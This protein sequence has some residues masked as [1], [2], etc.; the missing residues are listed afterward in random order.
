EEM[1]F[2]E[3]LHQ[4]GKVPLPP[5]IKREAEDGDAERYQTTY[6]RFDGSVA[7][8]TAGLHFT[9]N[10][11]NNLKQKEI[12][13]DFVT[14]HV[15]AGTF[16]PVKSETMEG[17]QMHAEYI[18]VN[19][20]LIEKLLIQSEKPIVAVGTTSMRT[21]ESLYWLGCKLLMNPSEFDN[22][23][24]FVSQWEVYQLENE[25]IS[26]QAALERLI[27]YLETNKKER[28]LARTQIIIAPGYSFKLTNGLVTNFHQPASTLLLLVSAFIGNDWRKV[29]DYALNN[30]FRFLSYGDGSLL[31]R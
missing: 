13:T 16:K 25:K 14:L 18:E 28:L 17:H 12:D 20:S 24:P 7:A 29:Y 27:F 26:L 15:G 10:V 1:R 11:L 4:A 19:K 22:Q 2:A 9:Q 30:D 3:V 31:M 23:L 6:A 8:P 5:Y 21:I